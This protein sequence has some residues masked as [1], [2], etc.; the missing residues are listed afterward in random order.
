MS[1]VANKMR[2]LALLAAM[3]ATITLSGC[4]KGDSQR[5]SGTSDA[6]AVQ[7]GTISDDMIILDQMAVDGT[8]VDHSAPADTASRPAPKVPTPSEDLDAASDSSSAPA[9]PP[10]AA[11][12]NAESAASTAAN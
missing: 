5:A 9:A 3:T 2:N 12:S 10:A 4:D 8:A 1:K 11:T 7:P 6:V